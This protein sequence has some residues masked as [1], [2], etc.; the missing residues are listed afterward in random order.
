MVDE[1]IAISPFKTNL[2]SQR[3]GETLRHNGFRHQKQ[4]SSGGQV[5]IVAVRINDGD[6]AARL[7]TRTGKILS[8]GSL[9]E[10]PPPIKK[11]IKLKTEGEK[12]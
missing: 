3:S 2:R 9:M 6:H 4:N 11:M 10:I 8:P 12:K 5:E 1:F 7:K